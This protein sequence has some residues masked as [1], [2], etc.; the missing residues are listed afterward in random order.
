MEA[1][2]DQYQATL[3]DWH[4]QQQQLEDKL[5]ALIDD[6]KSSRALMQQEKSQVAEKKTQIQQ[7]E[8]QLQAALETLQK[9][10]TDQEAGGAVVDVFR[11]T[12]DADQWVEDCRG[13]FPDVNTVTTARRVST[14]LLGPPRHGCF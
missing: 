11:F 9:V 6:S 14:A 5:Q 1:Q 3:T 12:D 8:Q 7:G 2:L 10:T 13:L 4:D